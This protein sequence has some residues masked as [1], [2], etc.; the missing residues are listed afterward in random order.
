M[1]PKTALPTKDEIRSTLLNLKN[2]KVSNDLPAETFKYAATSDRLLT[3]IENLLSDIWNTNTNTVST[4]RGHS[5]LIA[6]WKGASK[7]S[8]TDPSTTEANKSDQTCV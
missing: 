6:L 7:G 8:A 2:G 3:E 1:S 5:K 4:S